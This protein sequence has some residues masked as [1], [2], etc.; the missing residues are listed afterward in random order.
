MSDDTHSLAMPPPLP[1]LEFTSGLN[2]FR[3]N[4][5]IPLLADMF[6]NRLQPTMPFFK[7]DF[8]RQNVD[9][10]RHITDPA[11]GSLVH[12]ICSLTL[13]QTVQ[14]EDK[15]VL[16]NR[17][18]QAEGHLALAVQLHAQSRFGHEPSVEGIMTSIFLFACNFCKGNH[19]A[20]K[21]HLRQAS[22]QA[23]M[24]ELHRV[25]TYGHVTPA[26]RDRR[27][28]TWIC[29]TIIE[30]IYSIQRDYPLRPNMLTGPRVTELRQAIDSS[31]EGCVGEDVT[32][33]EGLGNMLDQVDFIDADMV[34]CWKDS[35]WM[36]SPGNHITASAVLA[37]LRRYQAM[38]RLAKTT[39]DTA[40]QHADILITRHW[41]RHKVWSL[42]Y[43]HGYVAALN[44]ESELR[45]S[46]ALTIASDTIATCSVFDLASLET[47]GVGLVR[48]PTAREKSQG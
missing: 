15:G 9:R 39:A 24:M 1:P 25:N 17:E 36:E 32:A 20:A 48:R 18:M 28:R 37:L 41:M 42:G 3:Q 40:A 16:A 38:P 22:A 11:F 34:R 27:V 26:E 2:P 5:C 19:T 21:A 30:R 23:E 47:H 43:R 45:P 12:A 6:V 44:D 46:H 29:L 35:C 33:I 8:L 31:P 4:P 10:N 14:G 7:R 13:L